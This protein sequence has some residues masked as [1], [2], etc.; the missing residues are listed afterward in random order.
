MR[1]LSVVLLLCLAVLVTAFQAPGKQASQATAADITPIAAVQ[2]DS[3]V[4]SYGVGI[5]LPFLNTPYLDAT[6]VANALSDL[7]VRHVR[8]DLFMNNPRQYAGIKT[9]SDRGIKFNLIMGN[10]S[11]PDSAE[12]YVNTVATQLPPGSVESVEG[13]N[14]WDLFSGGSPTWAADLATR[15]KELY[16]A[17]KSN[18]ATADLPVLAP[19]LAFKW[20]YVTAGDMSRYADYANG[21]MYP[22]GYKPSNEISQI[23]TAIRGSI[24]DKPLVTT[25]SGYHNAMNTTNGHRPVPEDVAGVYTPRVLLEH[26]LR[27]EKRVYTY[28]LIDE[29]DNPGLTNPEAHFG[30]LRRDWS[31]KPAYTAM[32][33]LLG[34]LDDPGPSFT[35][36]SLPVKVTGYPSDGK[37]VLTQKRNGQ[38]VL[39]LWRDVSLYDPVTQTPQ[40]VTPT[41]VTLQLAKGMNLSVYRPSEG[42]APVTQTQGSTL[43][44][45]MGGSV[46]A[47]TIDP[48][49]VPDPGS[50][51]ATAGN[52]SATVSWQLPA[53]QADVTG[54]EVTREPGTTITLPATARSFNDTGLTN[55]TSYT[56]SV[57]AMSPDGNSQAVAAPP[58]VPATVPSPPII[59]STATGSGSV[60]VTWKAPTSNGGSPITGYQLLSGTKTLTVGAGTFKATLTGLPKNTTVRVGVRAKN[61]VGWGNQ[62]FTPY[63]K[64]KR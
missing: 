27:G 55:G 42:T 38:Y 26:Y 47:I 33:N 60:T 48:I 59:T 35:P 7:G 12:A 18:P 17:S 41:N 50:V 58:V 46:T 34:L 22:G 57:R 31:P 16:E 4:E 52:A 20:N 23:T 49:P 9:V 10:P 54:F 61:V 21:H 56:Y 32:K 44:L 2:A 3:L 53:T 1:R 25:E 64:T 24:P 43:P 8:D 62:A 5:H 29:F 14:E 13:S 37:Y 40:P 45:Q 19:A 15:Q 30:L 39:L 63:V 28:E 51:S 6:A 11:S 36:A